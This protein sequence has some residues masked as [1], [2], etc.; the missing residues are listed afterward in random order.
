MKILCISLGCDKNLVDSEKMLGLLKHDGFSF[1]D[2]ETEA[3]IIIINTC[4]FIGDAKE[5]SVNTI[6]EMAEYKKS[7]SCKALIVTGCMAQRYKEEITTEIPEVDAVIGTSTYD[8]I[9]H[10]LKEVLSGK[11]HIQCFHD[12]SVLPT[13]EEK[14]IITTGGCYGFLKI[15]E[16]CDKR[17]TYCI[18]PYLRGP[19]L[20][21]PE[22]QPDTGGFGCPLFS[23]NTD[24]GINHIHRLPDLIHRFDIVN[25]HQVKPEAV[26]MVF[27]YPIENGF[28]HKLTHHRAFA[29]SLIATS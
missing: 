20:S 5:E 17:C 14:R 10:V 11:E 7:G 12:L 26:H 28:H 15:A 2:D 6:L 24:C 1:T 4:C 22:I 27:L 8:E 19:Y 13:V 23:I 25:S 9:S 3:D 21:L 29:G 18:I 16:G